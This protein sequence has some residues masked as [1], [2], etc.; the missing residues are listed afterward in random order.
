[1]AEDRQTAA[2]AAAAAAAAEAL[3]LHL[4]RRRHWSALT[5]LHHQKVLRMAP[6]AAAAAAA[7]AVLHEVHLLAL[8]PA[9]PLVPHA[10]H[11]LAQQLTAASLLAWGCA[12]LPTRTGAAAAAAAA[13]AEAAKAEAL[14]QALA[15]QPQALP[16]K[17]CR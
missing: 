13:A 9:L 11:L 8:H 6:A 4:H 2:A 1:V 15:H 3:H 10:E 17:H 16:L 12:W 14:L 7:A 5:R